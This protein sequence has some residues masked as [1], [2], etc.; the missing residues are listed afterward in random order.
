MH[1]ISLCSLQ[2]CSHYF[3]VY[4]KNF[5]LH[6]SERLESIRVLGADITFVLMIRVK[7]NSKLELVWDREGKSA[8]YGVICCCD[9][10]LLS[11]AVIR[12]HTV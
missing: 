2:F 9:D 11:R 5:A 7:V 8:L 1:F 4:D 10:R 6:C 12:G 3:C